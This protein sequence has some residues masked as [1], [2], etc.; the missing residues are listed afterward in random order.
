[1]RNKIDSQLLQYVIES[2]L[3]KSITSYN[4]ITKKEDL[5]EVKELFVLWPVEG[6]HLQSIKE[7]EIEAILF[8]TSI[9]N[10]LIQQE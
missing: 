1:M 10:R 8:E 5:L 2:E 6:W 4:A 9:R 7:I 3:F